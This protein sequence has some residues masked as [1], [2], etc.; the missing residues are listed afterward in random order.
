VIAD[1]II[2]EV[3]NEGLQLNTSLDYKVDRILSYPAGVRQIK[4][5]Y[6]LLVK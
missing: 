5:L 1:L 4:D 3:V 6:S 2:E